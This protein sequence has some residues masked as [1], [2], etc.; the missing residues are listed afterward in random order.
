M[1]TRSWWRRV[2]AQLSSLARERCSARAHDRKI[3][4]HDLVEPDPSRQLTRQPAVAFDRQCL[5]G[6]I[7]PPGVAQ[8]DRHEIS[9]PAAT[10]KIDREAGVL[11]ADVDA[12]AFKHE[13]HDAEPG[14]RGRH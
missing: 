3:A 1:L 9:D 14:P 12:C 4:T 8:I 7:A 11:G 10:D 6:E 2:E 13:P 5:A